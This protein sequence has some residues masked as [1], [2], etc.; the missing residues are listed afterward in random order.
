MRCLTIIFTCS[1]VLGF[2]GCADE[3]L[4][5]VSEQKIVSLREQNRELSKELKQKKAKIAELERGISILSKVTPE[6]R[7]GYLYDLKKVKIAK[8]TNLYDEN[9]DGRY[10]KLLVYIQPIDQ[11]GDIIKA[12]GSID[13]QLWDLN[14]TSEEALIGEWH[15]SAEQLSKIWFGGVLKT[16]YRLDFDITDKIEKFEEPLTVKI[17]FTDYLRGKVFTEQKTIKPPS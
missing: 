17:T 11:Q 8:F 13:V 12:A 9:E 2:F 3:A 1:I 10:D 5:P 14:K 6:E 7:F 15:V 16:N 4:K